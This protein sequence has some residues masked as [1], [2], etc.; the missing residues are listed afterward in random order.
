ME[1]FRLTNR[2]YPES[3]GRLVPPFFDRRP[4]DPVSGR[5]MIYQPCEGASFIRCGVGPNGTG[6]RNKQAP[7]AWLWTYSTNAPSAQE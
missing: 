1:R 4:H 7:D 6:D 5:S 3:L 2:V